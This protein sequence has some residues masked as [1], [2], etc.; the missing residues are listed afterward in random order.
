MR[1]SWSDLFVDKVVLLQRHERT[2]GRGIHLA[3]WLMPAA[4]ECTSQAPADNSISLPPENGKQ[5]KIRASKRVVFPNYDFQ[6]SS[7]LSKMLGDISSTLAA[8]RR[9]GVFGNH[10]KSF[11][12]VE[13]SM[14]SQFSSRGSQ[15]PIMLMWK[16]SSVDH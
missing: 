9:L 14:P 4:G 8:F 11:G 3:R 10:R 7:F 5:K 12:K 15:L 6:H 1:N 2:L 13:V 16:V